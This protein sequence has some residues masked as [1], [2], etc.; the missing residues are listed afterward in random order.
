[1]N[2]MSDETTAR[3]VFL[4]D[5]DG[6]PTDILNAKCRYLARD[7]EIPVDTL[8]RVFDEMYGK[9]A[10]RPDLLEGHPVRFAPG[11]IIEHIKYGYRGIIVSV[12]GRCQASDA[13][14]DHMQCA[15]SGVTRDQPWYHVLVHDAFHTTYVA[16]Q[17]MRP[18][19]DI[20]PVRHPW[21]ATFFDRDLHGHHRRND[22]PWNDV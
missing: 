19:R 10:P 16:Q 9:D 22:T 4:E 12:D 5:W 2:P 15:A 17:N 21:I 3:D 14:Y 1:M 6:D 18:A 20:S 13:W 11:D 8:S 7:L